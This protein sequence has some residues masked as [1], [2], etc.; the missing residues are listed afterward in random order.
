M[1]SIVIPVYRDGDALARTLADFDPCG[2]E[3]I[4]AATAEDREALAALRSARPDVVW[5]ESPRGRGRQ[6]NAGAAAARG[7]WIVFLHADTQLPRGW[8]AAIAEA[9]RRGCAI[10]CF[11]FVLDSARMAARLIE[12]GVAARVRLL[13]LPYGDQGIFVRRAVFE[14]MGGFADLPIMEDVDLV[15]RTPGAL[16]RSALPAVTSARR[17]ERDGWIRRSAG[18]VLL[19]ARYFAGADPNRLARLYNTNHA[20]Q[21]RSGH[22]QL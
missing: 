17:W 3:V 7:E 15:R 18:N 11:R 12:I 2:A 5:I 20:D 19:V 21:N 9:Q 14:P 8:A 13:R 1:I 22:P 4:V 16:F 6:M 10:G